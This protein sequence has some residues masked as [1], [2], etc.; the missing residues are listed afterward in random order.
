MARKRD[1]NQILSESNDNF[2]TKVDEVD[3]T[4]TY[5]GKAGF[6]TANSDAKWQIQKVSVSGV[7]TTIAYAG[8]DD[9]FTNIWDNRASLSYS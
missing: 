9:D 4:T 2:T 3:T 7:V 1:W 6:G 5:I 8:G